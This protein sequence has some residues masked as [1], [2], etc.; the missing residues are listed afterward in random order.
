MAVLTPN[1][2][3]YGQPVMI[4]E[5]RLHDDTPEIKRYQHYINK[6]KEVAWKRWKK[7]VFAF[8]KGRI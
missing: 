5:E 3:L 1:T 6:C 2:V 7:I 8:E 4:P